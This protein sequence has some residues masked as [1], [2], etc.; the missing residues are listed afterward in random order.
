MN[1]LSITQVTFNN[2]KYLVSLSENY[3]FTLRNDDEELEMPTFDDIFIGDKKIT[4]IEFVYSPMKIPSNKTKKNKGYLTYDGIHFE[5]N[6]QGGMIYF[7]K[8]EYLFFNKFDNE[9]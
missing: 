6:R 9:K 7:P 2:K 8:I 3:N 4:E 5:L 1:N